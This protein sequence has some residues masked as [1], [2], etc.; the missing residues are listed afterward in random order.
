MLCEKQ[1]DKPPILV[2]ANRVYHNRLLFAIFFRKRFKNIFVA[3]Q[4]VVKGGFFVVS[5]SKKRGHYI[6]RTYY[7]LKDGTRIYARDYGK[8]AFRFFVED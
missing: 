4:N 8:K 5:K 2:S 6:F 3:F 7:T 1:G